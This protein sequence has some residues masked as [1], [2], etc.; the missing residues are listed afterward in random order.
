MGAACAGILPPVQKA[1][2]SLL[3]TLVPPVQL[4]QLWPDLILTL[5]RL[6]RPGLLQLPVPSLSN[7]FNSSNI[8]KHALSSLAQERVVDTVAQLYRWGAQ[9]AAP[10]SLAN[11]PTQPCLRRD[12][13]RLHAVCKVNRVP[14]PCARAGQ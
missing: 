10:A 6:I 3:P 1:A 11:N 4:P 2:L 12:P 8:N 7:S 9:P 14:E 5:L 13:A